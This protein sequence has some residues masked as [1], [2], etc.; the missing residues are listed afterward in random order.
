MR[1]RGPN[2]VWI[3]LESVRA[4]NTFLDGYERN[5]T[6][7]LQRISRHPD[8]VGFPNCFSQSMWTPASSASI[9][10]GTYLF[11]HRVGYDGKADEPLPEEILTLP[12]LLMDEGYRTACLTPNS[13]LSDVTGLDRG[14]ETYH[15]FSL[16][17]AF[18]NR[19]TLLPFVKYLIRSGT[20]GPG[21]SLDLNRHNKT[22]IMLNVLKRWIR[23][24]TADSAPFFLYTHCPNPH[25]PYTPPLKWLDQFTADIEFSATE[26]LEL[27][28]ETYGSRDRMVQRIAD[29]CEFSQAEWEALMAMY[30]A[31]IAYADEFVGVLYDYVRRSTTGETVFVITADHGDLFGEHGL[32]GHNLVLDDALTNVP[33]VIHGL[34]GVA[35]AADSVVQHVDVTRTIAQRLGVSHHQFSGVDLRKK[36][37]EYAI[38]QRG[39]PHFDEYL[40]ANPAF[41]PDRFHPTPMTALR[42]DEYKYV[43]STRKAELFAL[44]DERT[45]VCD[46]FTEVCD[47]LDAELD[48]RL[49][50][51]EPRSAAE[52]AE[53]T[54][55]MK[56]QL[57]RLGYL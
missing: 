4:A 40:D 11:E 1:N 21:L 50:S 29:G 2:V 54:D 31:E 34:D 56:E 45:D 48:S 14:F 43:R 53:Y 26:A 55:A 52:S 23:T 35:N 16:T 36:T 51:M 22:Y 27:S 5:T 8:G 38:S 33:L 39:V 24:L 42:S 12:Q 49:E 19:E 46:S 15:W 6:P 32:L 47:R 13:Y 3:T 18:R 25:L 28:L 10:T 44:P 9:L 30:D 17:D 41:D 7:N 57:S 37:P 20:Y